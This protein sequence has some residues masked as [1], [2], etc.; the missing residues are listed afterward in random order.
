MQLVARRQRHRGDAEPGGP[1]GDPADARDD[2]PRV[3]R[4]VRAGAGGEPRDVATF[5]SLRPEDLERE[6]TSRRLG[7]VTLRDL[8]L[9]WAVHDLDHLAQAEHALAQGLLAESPQLEAAYAERDT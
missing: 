5:S 6:A 9:Q 7:R 8:M 2:G 3:G 4:G 1:L